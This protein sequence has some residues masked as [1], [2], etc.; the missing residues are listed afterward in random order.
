ME[1]G[2]DFSVSTLAINAWF[3]GFIVFPATRVLISLDGTSL[4][5]ALLSD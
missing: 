2:E 5:K 4:S 1:G 3:I